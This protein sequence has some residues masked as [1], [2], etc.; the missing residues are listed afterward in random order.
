MMERAVGNRFAN[1]FALKQGRI[2][3]FAIPAK[4]C[5]QFAHAAKLCFQRGKISVLRKVVSD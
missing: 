4:L 5:F 3:V 2:A 1:Y